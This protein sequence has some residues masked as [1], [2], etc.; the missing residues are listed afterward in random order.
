VVSP[1]SPGVTNWGNLRASSVSLPWICEATGS[2]TCPPP[3]RATD[4]TTLSQTSRTLWSIWVRTDCLHYLSPISISHSNLSRGFDKAVVVVN[5]NVA[6]FPTLCNV[7][8]TRSQ[9]SLAF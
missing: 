6:L 8:V 5:A 4:W 2:L 9:M 7:K 1:G 3:L